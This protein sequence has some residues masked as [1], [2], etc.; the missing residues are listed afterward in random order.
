[1]KKVFYIP[2]SAFVFD[3]KKCVK[4]S[5]NHV[6]KKK[7]ERAFYLL[8]AFWVILN[9][10][11][12]DFQRDKSG[13]VWI[14][15]SILNAI[16]SDFKEFFD[17][18]CKVNEKR[19][20]NNYNV[21][22]FQTNHGLLLKNQHYYKINSCSGESGNRMKLVAYEEGTPRYEKINNI[23]QRVK[24]YTKRAR[25]SG[26]NNLRKSE[27]EVSKKYY[28]MEIDERKAVSALEMRYG[29]TLGEA[30]HYSASEK[31]AK[32]K[33]AMIKSHKA[34]MF[35]QQYNQIKNFNLNY[36]NT[37][38]KFGRIYTGMHNL[39]KEVRN[40]LYN[41][42]NGHMVEVYDMHGAHVVGWFTMCSSYEKM[43]G[44][45]LLSSTYTD[46]ILNPEDDP[47][48][49]ALRGKFKDDRTT[50][51]KAVLSYVF[52]SYKDC[53]YR[54]RFIARMRK[55]GNYD[56]M[57]KFCEA[58]NSIMGLYDFNTMTDGMIKDI[59][60]DIKFTPS[61]YFVLTGKRYNYLSFY[62]SY[63]RYKS[64]DSKR[65]LKDLERGCLDFGVFSI[66]VD[67]AYKA[68]LQYHVEQCLEEVFGKSS[69][70]TCIGVKK[71]FRDKSKGIKDYISSVLKGSKTKL[72]E[73]LSGNTPNASI[74]C[75]IAEGWTMF[76]N[77]V[78]ELIEK[79][80]C[81][82][83]ITLHDAILVP[84]DV[85]RKIDVKKLNL[86]VMLTFIANVE[87][88]FNHIADY[89]RG[90]IDAPFSYGRAA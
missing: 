9:N 5:T 73:C 50:V 16:S 86:K 54:G 55:V 77:V 2:E 68:M 51:K 81:E 23:L 46:Y 45:A 20:I 25:I 48:R 67:V 3:I 4:G 28:E 34:K 80:G 36:Y 43:R 15:S 26:R 57:V 47:Y 65:A 6:T 61:I 82:D 30:L 84:E 72:S 90:N 31:C 17:K 42:E 19:Y 56:E 27:D 29:I 10:N 66:L 32:N 85:A 53:T 62:N 69:V 63:G 89:F 11:Y 58:Y 75:Q 88:A 76:D 18:L 22:F 21:H 59:L 64:V 78:P 60:S 12:M 33:E 24:N 38:A 13:G 79:T 7:R 70:S 83:I 39:V 40:F 44:N 41:K 71:Y 14:S 37:T 74:M 8:S 52:A 49:F 87:Y 35:C 1:M